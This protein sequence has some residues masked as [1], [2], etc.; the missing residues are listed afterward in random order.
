MFKPHLVRYVENAKTAERRYIEPEP[1]KTIPLKPE[2]IEVIKKAMA[3]V[4]V[5]G[6][7][8]RAFAKAEYTNAGKTGT[9][10][11]IAIKAGEKYVESRVAERHRDHAL[12]I[13]F[14]PVEN[15]KIAL[16][17]LVENGGFGAV[18]AAPIARKAIDYYLLGKKP[19]EAKPIDKA[20]VALADTHRGHG[21]D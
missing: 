18:A 16:A 5:E 6:T 13:A 7:G 2:N 21:H 20:A 9:A 12:Y 19:G 3:G 4:N 10:Q 14:A 1:M 11:V 17:V 8:A 15:P